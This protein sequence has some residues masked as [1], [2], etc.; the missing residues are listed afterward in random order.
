MR[1]VVRVYGGAWRSLPAMHDAELWTEARGSSVRLRALDPGRGPAVVVLHGL[2]TSVDGLRQAVPGLD[3]YAALAGEGLR[4]LAVDWPGHGR[5]GGPRGLL[6][7]RLAMETVAEAVAVAR[8]RWDAPVGVLGTGLGG[9]LAFYAGLEGVGGDA[10]VAHTVLDLRDLRPVLRRPRQQTLLPLVARA[11]AVMGEGLQPR[12]VAAEIDLD[13]LLAAAPELVAP[14]A[15][16]PFPAARADLALVVA[17][18]VPAAALTDA[19][20]AGAGELLESLRVFDLYTGPQVGGGRKSVAVALRFRAPDRTLGESEV[21]AATAGAV[22]EAG[23]RVGA[24]LRS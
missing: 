10:V 19:V 23:E 24:V 18:D 6:G 12:T 9:T 4:V 15:P 16:S 2:V 14:V 11:R 21:A 22:R 3:P 8:A 13:A 7:Y 17:D 1:W 20:R 5:S